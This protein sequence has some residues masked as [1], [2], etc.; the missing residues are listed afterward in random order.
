[1]PRTR[2]QPEPAAAR[3]A[4]NGPASEV[5]TL[6]EAAGYLRVSEAEVMRLVE[7]QG[8][9]GRQV[10]KDWRFLKAAIQDWLRTGP[11]PKGAKDA[12]MALAGAWQDDPHA[13]EE[14]KEIYRR[15][16]RPMTEEE[17]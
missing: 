14:L 8:L 12:W 7:E 9:A 17:G 1:M 16:G 15:R 11:R 13:E 3:A 10:G 5:F 6:R 4:G 2:K